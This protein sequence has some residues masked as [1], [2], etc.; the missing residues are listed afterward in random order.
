MC[1]LAALF[2]L[3]GMSL[4]SILTLLALDRP[5]CA[6]TRAAREARDKV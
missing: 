3:G 5:W 6:K 4:G 2:I 1:P